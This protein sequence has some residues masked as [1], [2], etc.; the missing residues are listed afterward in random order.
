MIDYRVCMW[1]F[2]IIWILTAYLLI[3]RIEEVKKLK[4]LLGFEEGLELKYK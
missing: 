1:A 3:R 2:I 4:E